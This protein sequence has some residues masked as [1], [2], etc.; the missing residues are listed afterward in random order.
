M[1]AY[2]G[3]RFSPPAPVAFVTLRNPATNAVAINVPML[4][5]SGS[6]ATMVPQQLVR[7]L[8]IDTSVAR[9]FEVAG[10][11][12]TT[13]VQAVSLQLHFLGRGFHGEFLVA[14]SEYGI[15]GRNIVNRVPLLLDGPKLIWDEARR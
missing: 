13:F 1:P 8:G 10:V 9:Q 14:S 12:G 4:I 6:D 5:D 3:E 15:L 2:D 7:N 11:E